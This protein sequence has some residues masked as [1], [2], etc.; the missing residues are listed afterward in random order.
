[1]CLRRTNKLTIV[2]VVYIKPRQKT[3][4]IRSWEDRLFIQDPQ[5]ALLF[6][7]QIQGGTS[8]LMEDKCKRKNE[9]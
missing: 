7:L 5:Q 6:T 9:L 1:M 8:C 2:A 3:A 4:V